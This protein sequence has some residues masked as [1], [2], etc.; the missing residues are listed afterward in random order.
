MLKQI[1]RSVYKIVVFANQCDCVLSKN[2]TSKICSYK[3]SCMLPI[4]HGTQQFSL[5]GLLVSLA[6]CFMTAFVKDSWPF[7]SRVSGTKKR[8]LNPCSWD[9]ERWQFI[10]LPSP[11]TAH[12]ADPQTN[13]TAYVITAFKPLF[14]LPDLTRE[15]LPFIDNHEKVL[16]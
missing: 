16:C 13:Q 4:A 3:C 6:H 2:I 7:I 1:S 8:K 5:K 10:V 9:S 12:S 14:L 15:T 11:S